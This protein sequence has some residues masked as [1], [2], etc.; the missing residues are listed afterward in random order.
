MYSVI[1]FSPTG[2]A[3]YLA[4]KLAGGLNCGLENVH[5]LEFTDPKKLKKN[6]HLILLYPVHGFNAPRTVKRFVKNLPPGIFDFVSLISV[7]CSTLWVN[8][9]VSLDLKNT[10]VKKNYSILVDEVL[11]MPL[12]F[13]FSFAELVSYRLISESEK[14][15]ENICN[16]IV[17][18]VKTGHR[19]KFKSRIM[20]FIGKAEGPAARLFGLELHSGKNCIS[21]GICWEMCPEKNIKPNQKE[22]PKFGFNCLMCLRCVYNCP[23]KAI[24]PRFS[25]YVPIKNGYSFDD[26]KKGEK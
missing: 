3:K 14:T 18:E 25:K 13:V 6:K 4:E 10:L 21:C 12:T 16:A 24:S 15:M 8:G 9:A 20:N 17:N 26:F 1:Y 7:G 19:V 2:N 5:P 23:E 22:K 11:A